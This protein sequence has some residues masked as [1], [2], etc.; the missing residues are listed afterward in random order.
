MKLK[1]LLEFIDPCQTVTVH[2]HPFKAELIRAYGPSEAVYK[3]EQEGLSDRKVYHIY[4][5]EENDV[6]KIALKQKEKKL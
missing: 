3:A 2:E 5:E 1:K 6:V 4:S